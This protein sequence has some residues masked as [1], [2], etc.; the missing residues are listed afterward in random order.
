MMIVKLKLKLK[1]T[2]KDQQLFNGKNV[3]LNNVAK[4]KCSLDDSTCLKADFDFSYCYI[5]HPKCK[6]W[7][8][9]LMSSVAVDFMP[10]EYYD[11]V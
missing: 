9:V 1:L 4:K 3:N 7:E 8:K 5:T 6:K 10:D 2:M 11:C